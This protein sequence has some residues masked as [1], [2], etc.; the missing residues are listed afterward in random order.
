M[1]LLPHHGW[2]VV[3]RH[4]GDL[5]L[6]NKT[7]H[8]LWRHPN[9]IRNF[10]IKQAVGAG[11]IVRETNFSVLVADN[12]RWL[13][14]PCTP[15]S[16]PT[17]TCSLSMMS[18]SGVSAALK[19]RTLLDKLYWRIRSHMVSSK[20]G[21]GRNCP[22]KDIERK[23]GEVVCWGSTRTSGKGAEIMSPALICCGIVAVG[24]RCKSGK[25]I[26]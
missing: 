20:L 24:K 26:C 4:P 6:F 8:A 1:V 10:W 13:K 18:Q 21:H 3:L 23:A 19:V 14:R 12:R 9:Y 25:Q 11:H 16:S 17:N 5:D 7:K 2:K 22:T 15:C